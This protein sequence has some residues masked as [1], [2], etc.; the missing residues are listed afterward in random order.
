MSIITIMLRGSLASAIRKPAVAA[1]AVQFFLAP[2]GHAQS[3]ESPEY[4]GVFS[5]GGTPE[6]N[7]RVTEIINTHYGQM[8]LDRPEAALVFHPDSGVVTTYWGPYETADE[9]RKSAFWY[10]DPEWRA[11]LAAVVGSEEEAD[12]IVEEHLSL[13]VDP[14]SYVVTLRKSEGAE[15]TAAPFGPNADVTPVFYVERTT[16]YT[17]RGR[18]RA[19]EIVNEY[20][21]PAQEA[22]G[23]EFFEFYGIDTDWDVTVLF[24]RYESPEAA[25]AAMQPG[26]STND[27]FM[28][29]LAQVAGSEEQAAAIGEEF[30]GLIAKDEFAVAGRPIANGPSN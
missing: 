29:A 2:L 15:F 23:T 14:K 16:T 19:L 7:P 11:A 12:A 18:E 25:Q 28:A 4:Y 6:G 22:A 20:L 17:D 9:A 27:D 26:G 30:S 21:A 8:D 13:L 10:E 24:G 5:G 1:L 3:G